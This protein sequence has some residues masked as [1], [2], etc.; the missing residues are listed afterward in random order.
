MGKYK[1]AIFLAIFIKLIGTMTELTLPYILEYMID[2]VV[3]AGNMRDVLLWGLLMFVAAI[4]CRQF[5]VMA[6]R[7]AINNAHKVSFDVRQALFKKTA[8]LSGDKFDSFGLPSLISRMTSDSYNVQAAVAQLQSLCVR[9]PMML[10]GGVVMTLLMDWAL[11]MILIVMLPFLICVVFFVSS[12]G[13]PLYTGVQKKLDSVVRIMRENITGIRVVKALS[14]GE[15]EKRRFAAANEDM[16]RTDMRA[17]TI[18]AIPGP[19]MQ[20]CLN[21]GLTMVVI[22]GAIRV[23]RGQMQPGVILAFLTYFNMIN[24]GVMGLNRIFM[25]MSKASASADRI[26]EVISTDD[27]WE[28]YLGGENGGGHIRFNNVSFSYGS[29]SRTDADFAGGKRELALENISFSLN[30]G[31]SLGIIG[32]TGCGKTT[33]VNLLMR[34]Y[35]P[36]SGSITIDDR[37]I[38]SYEKDELRR[39]FGVVFQNDMV[40][41]DSIKNNIDFGRGIS[42]ADLDS[43]AEDAVASEYIDSLDGKMEYMAAIKGAN[44]SGGQKQRLLVARALA[45]DPEILILDDSSS[46]LDYKTDS[47]MRSAIRKNHSDSTLIMIAQRV[48][49]IMGMDHIMVMDNGTCIGYGTHEELMENCPA[50]RETF[51]MQTT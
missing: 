17:G 20:L 50:Y 48:S 22:F 47:Q 39:K 31:E 43:A 45:A 19:F 33:I 12:K 6:N 36:D 26:D 37:D 23:N 21:I 24:M 3:P 28:I 44:L 38:R 32:P 27:G 5:N 14:K 34:F 4:A 8:N 49:S 41:N 1:W 10:F 18:M 2:H 7:R 13:I 11:A 16:A 30:K 35:N 15:F 46:A 42:Q 51:E 25:S 9:A 40:F 29:E